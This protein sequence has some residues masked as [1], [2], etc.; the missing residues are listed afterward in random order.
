MNDNND[1]FIELDQIEVIL[2]SV[3]DIL[4]GNNFIALHH[5]EIKTRQAS[6]AF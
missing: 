4:A 3:V 2:V 5:A 6:L 1:S